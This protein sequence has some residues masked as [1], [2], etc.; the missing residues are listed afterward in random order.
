[1]T[2][3]DAPKTEDVKV[4]VPFTTDGEWVKELRNDL[5]KALPR[6]EVDVVFADV[7]EATMRR[8]HG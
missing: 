4:V 6:A 1:M 3:C 8:I 5:E 2:N 7:S